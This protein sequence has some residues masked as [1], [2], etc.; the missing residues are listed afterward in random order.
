MKQT[1]DKSSDRLVSIRID[2]ANRMRLVRRVLGFSQKEFALKLEFSLS[3]YK[4]YEIARRDLPLIQAIIFCEKFNIE[5][6]WLVYGEGLPQK[7]LDNEFLMTL[8][9]CK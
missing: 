9:D 5:L 8:I 7:E 1:D 3:S 4:S 6:Q 2:I